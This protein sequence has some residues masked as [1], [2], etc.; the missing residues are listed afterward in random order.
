MSVTDDLMAIFEPWMTPDL[1]DYLTVVGEMF[2][3]SE[4]VIVFDPSVLEAAEVDADELNS[5]TAYG[6]LLDLDLTAAKALAYLAQFVGERLPKGL[7]EAGQREWILDRPNSRRGTM[8]SIAN[9]AQ[10][11]MTGTRLVCIIERADGTPGD[12]PDDVTVLTYDYETPDPIQVRNDLEDTF[13]LELSLH[14]RALTNTTWQQVVVRYAT[15][16]DVKANNRTWGDLLV[17]QIGGYY[18]KR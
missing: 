18:F 7:D 4:T 10:R 2:S 3:E 16:A 12:H 14:Y 15:W 5:D 9:A 8:R 11:T 6:V 1:E 13:P 17:G